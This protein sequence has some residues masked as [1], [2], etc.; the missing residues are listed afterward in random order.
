MQQ[1]SLLL[2]RIEQRLR[3]LDV[4]LSITLWNGQR[5]TVREPPQVRV[6]VRSPQ[7]LATLASPTMGELARHYVEQQLDLE[8]EPRQIIRLGEALS[9]T[10]AGSGNT[11]SR[12]RRWLAHSRS[13]DSKAIRHHYDVGDEFF[14]L[15]LDRRRVYSCAYFRRPEDTLDIA[16][17]QKLDHICRK[18]VL[19]PGERLLDIGCGWGALL[20]WA[21]QRYGVRAT[22]I[23][24]SENQHAYACA[25][26]RE[27][28]LEGSCEVK[29]LDY[30][31]V[32]EGEPYDKIASVGMFEHVGRKNLPLYFAKIRRLLKPGGLVMNHG[33]TLNAL[34]Q[35]ELGSDIGAFIDEYVFPGGE[36]THIAHVVE[37]MSR[38]GLEATDVESLR[39]HYART[40]WQWVQRLEANRAAALEHVGEKIYRIWRIYMAGSARAFERGWLSIYQVLA[41]RPGADGSL[42]LPLT[43][44]HIYAV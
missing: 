34:D 35:Y 28:G 15:W 32:P 40:L 42:G 6:T 36:L 25:R 13:F 2:G 33:I 23:T 7:V 14:G 41:G 4:P 16:Q 29:L 10:P 8:G 30:R 18:L 27:A 24:L 38:Q 22:G 1:E 43:R 26:I 21:A 3:G 37:E 31:D 5:V 12:L 44:E 19:K 20:M 39:P 11:A 17:E 9:G